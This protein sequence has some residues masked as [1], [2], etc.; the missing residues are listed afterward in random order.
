MLRSTSLAHRADVDD[1]RL[2][3]VAREPGDLGVDIV[4]PGGRAL[5]RSRLPS[6]TSERVKPVCLLLAVTVTPAPRPL[7]IGDAALDDLCA[8]AGVAYAT[9][10][11]ASTR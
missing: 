5:R 7:R 4:V 3:V 2:R 8:K 6:V 11:T 10:H 1:D 9:P